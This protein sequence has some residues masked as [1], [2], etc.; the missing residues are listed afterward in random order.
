MK[1]LI[2]NKHTKLVLKHIAGWFCIVLGLIMFITPGQGILTVLIG[3]FLLADEVP[4]FGRLKD[5]IQHKFPK[6]SDYVHRKGE[7]LRAKFHH[8]EG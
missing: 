3:V 2:W 5:W 1:R 4:M 7:Q 6:T 8:K